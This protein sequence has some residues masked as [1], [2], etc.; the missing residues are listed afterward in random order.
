MKAKRS[1]LLRGLLIT[2]LFS[3]VLLAGST[4]L[5]RS[6]G[7]FSTQAETETVERAVRAAMLTCYAVEGA[8]PS[9]VDYLRRYY[10]L[11]WDENAY[12][13]VCDAFASNIMPD[14]RVLEKG[15]TL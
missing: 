5:F 2:L 3:A 15:G 13:V 10:G 12:I 8:Y 6:I 11:T 4:A 14:V 1:G 7:S 9:D